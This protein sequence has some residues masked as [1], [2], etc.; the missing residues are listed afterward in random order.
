MSDG[1]AA[2]A[3]TAAANDESRRSVTLAWST[4][5]S[6]GTAIS[7]PHVRTFRRRS[8]QRRREGEALASKERE[9]SMRKARREGQ[10]FHKVDVGC[11][12]EVDALSC[13]ELPY[14]VREMFSYI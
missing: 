7:A 9:G 13:P 8:R 5:S 1:G 14:V 3:S 11:E 10:N 4:V 2:T 12:G 6:S